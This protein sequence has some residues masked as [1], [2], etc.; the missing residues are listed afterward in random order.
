MLAVSLLKDEDH[1][2]ER[3]RRRKQIHEHRLI[4]STMLRK[5]ISRR[6]GALR[7]VRAD[8]HTEIAAR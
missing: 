4:G 5:T 8:R 2:P 6:K 7:H 3:G 1:D